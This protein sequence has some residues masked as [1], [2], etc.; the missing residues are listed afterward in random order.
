MVHGVLHNIETLRQLI[1]QID[2]HENGTE[3]TAD[4]ISNVG[5]WVSEL[6]RQVFL[7]IY[8]FWAVEDW[9]SEED[10]QWKLGHN[11]EAELVDHLTSIVVKVALEVFNFAQF[12]FIL[13]KE[14]CAWVTFLLFSC[15]YIW[16]LTFIDQNVLIFLFSR[17]FVVVYTGLIISFTL[18]F[19]ICLLSRIA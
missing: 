3:E 14:N 8:S 17:T 1:C 10:S 4:D 9:Q 2:M 18:F 12:F 6:L 11:Q 19:I 7:S 13:T 15:S 16:T 5:W